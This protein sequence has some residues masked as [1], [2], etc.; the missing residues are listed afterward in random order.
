[1]KSH[2]NINT[3][4][5]LD[6]EMWRRIPT[7]G[8]S[9]FIG[10]VIGSLIL[11]FPL[12]HVMALILGT[13]FVVLSIKKIHLALY[14]FVFYLTF[15]F[16][17][18]NLGIFQYLGDINYPG[19]PSLLEMLFGV[20]LL[21]FAVRLLLRGKKTIISTLNL[22]LM[23]YL[24]LL[25]LSLLIG[26]K[27][28]ANAGLIW[29]EFKKF[30]V[31]VL[32]FFCSVNILNCEK[33]IR[34]VLAFVFSAVFIKSSLGGMYY[35]VAMGNAFFDGRM[36][37]F[38]TSGD[39]FS[40]VTAI[41]VLVSLIT[42]RKIRGAKLGLALLAASPILF[43]LIFSYR[44]H[45]WLG[46]ILSLLFLLM[47]LPGSRKFRILAIGLSM[48]LIVV[49]LISFANLTHSARLEASIYERFIS[50]FNKKTPTIVFRFTEWAVTVEDILEHPVLGLGL[51]S[52][53]RPI[54]G[55]EQPEE[56]P[57]SIVHNALLLLWMKMGI[58]TVFLFLWYMTRYVIL[59][60]RAARVK[61]EH[62]LQPLQIGLFASFGFMIT[63]LGGAPT[64]LYYRDT[65]L[66][67]LVMALVINLSKK[68]EFN[69]S[70][71][72]IRSSQEALAFEM[73]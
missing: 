44:R 53:H 67:A 50:A 27:N 22:P 8:P 16:D 70:S 10:I 7:L 58:L 60:I 1:M 26:L 20:L 39:Q 2:L 18:M 59:G 65:C 15:F 54:G 71:L 34:L 66:M 72:E 14:F 36:P 37:F 42:F 49:F 32:F 17:G 21:S 57:T 46:L 45:A 33:R 25:A 24:A 43:A 68:I 51:G 61:V 29:D 5:L 41:V 12:S 56:L 19:I 6:S 40:F 28:G 3:F 38:K 52:T 30:L 23:I 73:P 69:K 63:S 64:W 62:P 13:A 4:R 9:I 48:G 31:P 47:L 11:H 35:L 55:I